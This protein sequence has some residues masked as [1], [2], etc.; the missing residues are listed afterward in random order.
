[1]SNLSRCF[2]EGFVYSS[3]LSPFKAL[4]ISGIFISN[5]RLDVPVI[6]FAFLFVD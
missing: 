1:M 3:G 5:F 4:A 6:L 2:L